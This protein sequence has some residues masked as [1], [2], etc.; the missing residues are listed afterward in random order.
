MDNSLH[1]CCRIALFLFPL[2][3][4][5][6]FSFRRSISDLAIEIFFRKDSAFSSYAF[7]HFDLLFLWFDDFP[8]P[9]FFHP[10]YKRNASYLVISLKFRLCAQVMLSALC[11]FITLC[12]QI[13]LL[14]NNNNNNKQERTVYRMYMKLPGWIGEATLRLI[15]L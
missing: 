7:W 2:F 9:C 11:C 1:S 4:I 3:V 13:V 8:D 6:L 10:L 14:H 15:E 12:I 5:F